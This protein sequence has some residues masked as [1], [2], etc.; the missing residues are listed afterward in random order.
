MFGEAVIDRPSGSIE[1]RFS[2]DSSVALRVSLVLREE[3]SHEHL[4]VD[5]VGRD[6]LVAEITP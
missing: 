3:V 4:G 1:T 5:I 6:A 2:C